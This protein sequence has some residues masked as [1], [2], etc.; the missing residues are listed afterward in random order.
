MERVHG[1]WESQERTRVICERSGV[2]RS[3]RLSREQWQPT[4]A[5]SNGES[6][7]GGKRW[8]KRQRIGGES[9]K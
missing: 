2:S 6:V 7:V 8:S 4:G 9:V 1:L 3:G 5:E